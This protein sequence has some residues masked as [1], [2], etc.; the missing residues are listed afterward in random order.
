MSAASLTAKS[1]CFIP[2][3]DEVYGVAFVL[4]VSNEDSKSSAAITATVRELNKATIAKK[5]DS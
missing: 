5:R 3:V 2:H 4:S 1:F